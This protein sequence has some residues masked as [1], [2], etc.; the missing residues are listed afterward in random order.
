MKK[1]IIESC[2]DCK[3]YNDYFCLALEKDIRIPSVINEDCPLEDAE[4]GG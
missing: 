4:E 2:E 3:H 1:L